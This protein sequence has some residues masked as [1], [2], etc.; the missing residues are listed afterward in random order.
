MK[1]ILEN[2]DSNDFLNA[3][4]IANAFAAW[5]SVESSTKIEE[6]VPKIFRDFFDD[7]AD[8]KTRNAIRASLSQLCLFIET[9][10]RSAPSYRAWSKDGKLPIDSHH[11]SSFNIGQNQLRNIALIISR[12]SKQKVQRLAALKR[13]NS[14]KDSSRQDYLKTAKIEEE[15]ENIEN[16]IKKESK[17]F[18]TELHNVTSSL[19]G[20]F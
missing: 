7:I 11:L 4:G 13:I 15:I 6:K 16:E 5:Q 12:K 19:G 17:A 1:E 9:K 14:K 18:L 3:R 10:Y 8:H 20:I 2:L